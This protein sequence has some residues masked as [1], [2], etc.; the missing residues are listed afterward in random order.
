MKVS[1]F[2][3]EKSETIFLEKVDWQECIFQTDEDLWFVPA[4]H[5]F[6]SQCQKCCSSSPHPPRPRQSSILQP[7]PAPWGVASAGTVHLPPVTIRSEFTSCRHNCQHEWLG[8]TSPESCLEEGNFSL[9]LIL[10]RQTFLSWGGLLQAG[11]VWLGSRNTPFVLWCLFSPTLH[12]AQWWS[13]WP[14][15]AWREKHV[16]LY[17]YCLPESCASAPSAILQV[18]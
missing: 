14:E 4:L 16:S 17:L 8:R 3:S 2:F 10:L 15:A 1:L 5:Q 9:A 18:P 12:T 6:N 7:L 11:N 13:L